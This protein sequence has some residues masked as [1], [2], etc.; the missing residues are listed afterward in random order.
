MNLQVSSACIRQFS[1]TAPY[2]Q[3]N[4]NRLDIRK[5]IDSALASVG[6]KF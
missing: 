4:N 5:N 3:I 6:Y 2:L 1:A